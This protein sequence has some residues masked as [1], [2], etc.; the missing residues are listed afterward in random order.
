MRDGVI[1]V[2]PRG[3]RFLVG[4]RAA[5]KPAPG[6]WTQVSGKLEP[7]ETEVEAIAREAREEIACV[8]RAVRKL[9]QGVS[10]NGEY[11]LHYWLCEIKQGEPRINNDELDELRW[12]TVQEHTRLEPIFQED[13]EVVNALITTGE[14]DG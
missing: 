14:S 8:V 2:L 3:G 9:R 6:Y 12:V 5:H 10:H 4:R 7:G 13:V 11:R 1:L